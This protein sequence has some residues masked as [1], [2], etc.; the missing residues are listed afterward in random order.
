LIQILGC[1]DFVT[2]R[3]SSICFTMMFNFHN[4]PLQKDKPSPPKDDRMLQK[5]DTGFYTFDRVTS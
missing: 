4:V 5:N 1:V 2:T 3:T